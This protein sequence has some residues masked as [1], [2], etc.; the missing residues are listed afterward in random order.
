M[1]GATVGIDIGGTHVRFGL[2]TP[3]GTLS[4]FRKYPRAEVLPDRDPLLLADALR[5]FLGETGAAAEA[6]GIGIPGTLS[7][8]GTRILRVPNLPV[9]DGLPYAAQ[10]R[11][12][13]GL[14]AY[15]ANDTVMLLTGDLWRLRLP[16]EGL[17]LG[18][19][20]GT[21]LGS[22]LFYN[23]EPLMGKNG[24]NELG[25]FPVPRSHE[26]CTCGNVGC[27]E[28]LV[29]G[30]TL[31]RLRAEHFPETD[32]SD[33][34]TAMQGS[35]LLDIWLDDLACLL[36]GTVNLLDPELLVLGG[37]VPAMRDFPLERLKALIREKAMKPLP[38]ETLQLVCSPDADDTGVIGAARYAAA[39]NA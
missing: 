14:P 5:A 9:L 33:L 25:H 15:L 34:F 19:Y 7:R 20:V 21:G 4:A 23:G 13:T 2:L 35:E 16:T 26:R 36:A 30:R 39:R 1:S 3:E 18:V 6:V 37:G 8:D 24:L 11:Q 38:A 29:S 17:I 27:A 12:Q 10:I 32:I 22:A 28:N 31:Q